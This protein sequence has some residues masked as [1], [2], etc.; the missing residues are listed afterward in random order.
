MGGWVG[1]RQQLPWE[2]ALEVSGSYAYDDYENASSFL[3]PGESVNDRHDHLVG[4][5]AE[6]ERPITER[7]TATA[8][9]IFYDNRSNTDVFDYHRHIVGAFITVAFGD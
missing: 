1:V 2:L 7:I 3:L 9:Y 5:L 6:L 4:V 8:R